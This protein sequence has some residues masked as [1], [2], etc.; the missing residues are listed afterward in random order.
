[1]ARRRR[2]ALGIDLVASR[3]FMR[4]LVGLSRVIRRICTRRL[5]LIG[6]LVLNLIL[7]RKVSRI[8][9]LSLRIQEDHQLI[10]K[11]FSIRNQTNR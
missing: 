7:I 3:M 2:G 9:H 5:M 4:E 8:N 10:L 6:G 11:L 1:M